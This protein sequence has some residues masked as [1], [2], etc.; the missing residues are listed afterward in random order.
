ME[1]VVAAY[2]LIWVLIFGYTLFLGSRQKKL[3]REIELLEQ[4]VKDR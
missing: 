1:A 4:A 3:A 2:S